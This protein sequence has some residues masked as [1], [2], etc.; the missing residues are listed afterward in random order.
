MKKVREPANAPVWESP[1]REAP[2]S[3][4][5]RIPSMITPE[6]ASYLR[7]L[8]REYWTGE[9]DVVEI[10]P[11]LGGST[12]CLASGMR[13]CPRRARDAR[14]HAADNF[15]WRSF[16]TAPGV[17]LA[18]G[19]SFRPLFEQNLAEFGELIRVHEVRLPDEP[20]GDIEFGAPMRDYDSGLPLFSRGLLTRPVEIVFV[21]GAKSWTALAYVLQELTG[22]LRADGLLVLQDFKAPHAYWVPMCVAWLRQADPA[23][24]E[25]T[26]VL[27]E[28][29]VAWRAGP[30]LAEAARSL[31]G[32]IG[33][34]A[35]E[36]GLALIDSAADV[37]GAAGDAPGARI[38]RLAGVSWLAA[39]GDWAAADERLRRV[40]SEWPLRD[41][42]MELSAM[43]GW[44]AE[45]SPL[46]GTPGWATRKRKAYHSIVRA[47][48][49]LRR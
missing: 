37:L 15:R 10:G 31:P 18:D 25:L 8:G 44:L 2:E 38:V 33:D 27:P 34:I 6:E 7:W 43:R 26:H 16:M 3:P 45:R 39:A 14:L 49:R 11:W 17:S 19:E 4:P 47:L 12:W 40:E 23:V 28:N 9:G 36:L 22:S 35:P 13:D 32:S 48:H 29:T 41:P 46:A 1:W 5:A 30:E 21:D 42:G 24:L 20:L